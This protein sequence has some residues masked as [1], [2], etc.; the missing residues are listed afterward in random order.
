MYQKVGDISS[1]TSKIV[2]VL[3]TTPLVI[4]T[5]YPPRPDR[6][7][8]MILKVTKR[9]FDNAGNIYISSLDNAFEDISS[10]FT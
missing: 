3:S 2:N 10:Y 7:A 4:I 9:E 5:S 6:V 8:K 1:K